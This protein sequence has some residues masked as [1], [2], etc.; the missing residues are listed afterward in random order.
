MAK[1]KTAKKAPQKQCPKCSGHVHVRK[2]TCD[3]GH[4]F[5]TTTKKKKPVP[6][7]SKAVPKA[8]SFFDAL[9]SEREALQ[10]RIEKIDELLK[11]Y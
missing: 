3:C 7:K 4:K 8:A 2:S 11:S 9:K 10:Q 1:K 6:K 5:G